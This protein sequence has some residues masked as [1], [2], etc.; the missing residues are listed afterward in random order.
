MHSK[1]GSKVCN[2]CSE[3]SCCP[4]L[5]CSIGQSHTSTWEQ[6]ALG[7]LIRTLLELFGSLLRL[8]PVAYIL[9]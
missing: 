2:Y 6:C 7:V 9:L 5:A 1:H 4:V 3:L 8:L